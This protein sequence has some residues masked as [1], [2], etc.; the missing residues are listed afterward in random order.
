MPTFYCA[1]IE[2]NWK[3]DPKV[4]IEKLYQNLA[5][6]EIP[7]PFRDQTQ[8]ILEWDDKAQTNKQI[9]CQFTKLTP[10]RKFNDS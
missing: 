9:H 1:N 7:H 10:L 2:T 5:L 3:T 6:P 4:R 8:N